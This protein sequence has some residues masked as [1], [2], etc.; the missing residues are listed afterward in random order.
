MKTIKF[1]ADIYNINVIF[2]LGS[3]VKKLE[4]YAIGEVPLNAYG[5]FWQT[6]DKEG[7][8]YFQIWLREMHTADFFHELIHFKNAVFK[9]RGIMLDHD[10]DEPE[11]YFISY[12]TDQIL[13]RLHKRK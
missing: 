10:N 12:I 7:R 9:S 8:H 5:R 1:F 2:H 6:E 13:K 3:D 11:A 4:K